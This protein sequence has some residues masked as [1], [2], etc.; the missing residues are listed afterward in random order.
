MVT[1][2][3]PDGSLRVD[4]YK[5]VIDWGTVGAIAF[6]GFVIFMIIANL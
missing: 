1:K 4:R 6:W 2:Y 3:K 5:K